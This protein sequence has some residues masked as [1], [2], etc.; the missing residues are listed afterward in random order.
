MSFAQLPEISPAVNLA[1]TDHLD[2]LLRVNARIGHRTSATARSQKHSSTHTKITAHTFPSRLRSFALN[3]SLSKA[4][5]LP[6]PG[7]RA[8]HLC[9]MSQL[10]AF[11]CACPVNLQTATTAILRLASSWEMCRA[12]N[13]HVW[14]TW[15]W[16]AH[17]KLKRPAA[18]LAVLHTEHHCVG[19]CDWNWTPDC[20]EAT[21]QLPKHKRGAWWS[22]WHKSSKKSNSAAMPCW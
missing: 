2:F 21:K 16:G 14:A 4:A 11:E 6:G 19:Q 13:Q 20:F 7:I 17:W 10:V 5:N 12:Q 22:M 9:R 15:K 3:P 18:S 8:A 1:Q